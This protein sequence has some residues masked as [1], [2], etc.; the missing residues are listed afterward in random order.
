M[1][2]YSDIY[3]DT[4]STTYKNLIIDELKDKN[5]IFIHQYIRDI[6]NDFD[7]E[8]G[9]INS[10][11][12]GIIFI[13][14]TKDDYYF[15]ML[16]SDT[17]SSGAEPHYIERFITFP[18]KQT[19]KLSEMKSQYRNLFKLYYITAKESNDKILINEIEKLNN[20]YLLP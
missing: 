10:W 16:E 9:F 12:I 20:F 7:R 3:Y 18:H 14:K 8:Y 13:E 15:H 11:I 6:D 1:Q 17:R 5:I 19:V 2:S 4:I